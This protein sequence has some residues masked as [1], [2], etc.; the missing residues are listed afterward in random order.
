[1]RYHKDVF[2]PQEAKDKL[3]TFVYRL[4]KMEWQYTPHCCDN[5]RLR[6]L[7]ME[8][9]LYYIK[10]DLQLDVEQIFEFYTN[11]QDKVTKACFR[12]DYNKVYDLIL[13]V[14]NQK[15][16]VTI[17]INSKNDKHDTLKRELYARP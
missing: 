4:N 2:F 15:E 11:G 7:D 3:I 9:L 14:G 17:Y 16:I 13:V 5:I 1:M 6:V 8:Q 10:N 12:I